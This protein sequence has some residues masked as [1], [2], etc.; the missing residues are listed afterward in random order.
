MTHVDI[1][2]DT[3]LEGFE[4]SPQQARLWRAQQAAPAKPAT[5]VI[6]SERPLDPARLNASLAALIERHEILRT[7]YQ[8]LA[9]MSLPMQVISEPGQ[10]LETLGIELGFDASGTGATLSLPSLHLDSTSL[11]YLA[12]EWA[13]GYLDATLLDPPLQY[14]DYAAWRVEEI[15][16]QGRRFWD[17]Q[18]G[19][20]ATD[21]PLPWLR[22]AG[23]PAPSLEL[24]TLN[25]PL[26]AAGQQ[27]WSSAAS[28]LGITPG[29]LALAAW[30]ALWQRHSEAE[31]LTLGYDNQWRAQ[32][33]G[34][35]LGL[36]AE[37]LP[38]TL[39]A[40]DSTRFATLCQQIE[41]R[42]GV[43]ND[44]R[45]SYPSQDPAAIAGARLPL[46]FRELPA[47]PRSALN[48]AGWQI[49]QADSP[50]AAFALLLQ[51][52]AGAAA[53]LTLHYA[54][55][56]YDETR[57][58]LLAE[59]FVTL[60]LQACREPSQVL[61]G[62]SACSAA[63]QLHQTTTLAASLPLSAAQ[64]QAYGEIADLPHLAAC[65]AQASA[66]AAKR[67]AVS[68]PSGTLSHAELEQR[69]DAL[70]QRLLAQ[71]LE[72]GARIAHFLARD[73]D[74]VVAL[75]AILRAGACYVPI[76]PSY[77]AER[78]EHILRDSQAQWV[79]THSALLHDLPQAGQSRALLIDSTEPVLTRLPEP[80]PARDQAAYL[81]YTSGS[82]GQPKGVVISH[83]NALHS[84]AARLVGYRQPVERFLLLSSFAFDSSIA[85]LFWSLAQRGCLH[86]ASEAEQKDPA[87]LARLIRTHGVSHLLALPSLYALLLEQLGETPSSLNTA[88][89]AGESCPPALVDSHY[90]SQPQ[91]RLYNEYGPTEASVWSTVAE[92][93]PGLGTQPVPIG[94]A[95]AHSHVYLLDADGA[96]VA[97]GLKGEIHIAGPGLSTGYLGLPELT[98]EKFVRA[99]HP[100]LNGQRLYRSGDFAYRDAD[101]QLV[102]LGRTDSQVKLRGYRIELG[103]IE[104]AL[105]KASG[106]SQTVV[107]LDT[108]QAQPSLRA[109]VESHGGQDSASLREALAL[110]LPAHMI[111]ADIQLLAQLPRTANGKADAQALLAMAANHS[112]AP[113]QAPQ[114]HVELV[115]A[116]LWQELLEADVIGRNDDFFALGGHSLLVVRLVHRIRASL[117]V[118]IPVSVMFEHPT[119]A[120]LAEQISQPGLNHAVV[121]LQQGET[122]QPALFCLHQPSG[123]VHHYL[124]M[125]SALPA[126]LPIYGI[127][128]PAGSQARE[129]SLAEL[130]AGYLTLIRAAQPQGPYWL[131]GWSMGGLLALELTRQLEQ[132][133]ET[134][135][136]LALFD[137]TFEAQDPALDADA[138]HA[139]L[140]E[141]LTNESRQRLAP[142]ALAALHAATANRPRMEQLQHALLEWPQVHGL[143]L[144]APQAYV[145]DTLSAMGDARRWVAGY[146]VPKVQARLQLWWAEETLAQNPQLPQRWDALSHSTGHRQVPG[147]HESIL[148]EPTFHAQ[149]NEAL[150]SALAEKAV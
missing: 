123:G 148:G 70:T 25:C 96:P 65:F 50:S 91:A 81:I 20:V 105:C 106:A 95:I 22:H 132:Q 135:E 121:T 119:L 7:H 47:S 11:L 56:A 149:L 16:D 131:C 38:L 85:G 44:A 107:L 122:G 124:P 42:C 125:I 83:A 118:E 63:E 84:L 24:H 37:P 142:E 52:Q 111:P 69:V 80:T 3:Q 5:L 32:V 97:R 17:E 26:D 133:G 74:A 34:D 139:L 39:D 87:Q 147:D 78:I 89:V 128:L 23:Q 145:A 62:L 79:V 53:S 1:P 94:R 108:H 137:S 99:R 68:G 21:V 61:S 75:V 57:V 35:A 59:Q 140:L 126:Q 141:E 30:A 113:Y 109:F 92:C 2:A 29:T 110:M 28:G 8:R 90:R 104:A 82:T 130:A 136:F 76:D 72:P 66:D 114:G 19:N 33:L 112:H 41:E 86:L 51:Y 9:G 88:I 71:D 14:A 54:A 40:S 116:A 146:Q 115:L 120:R 129:A 127:A 64:Q 31:R 77:P 43:L 15:D 117:G 18:L 73:L 98:D 93:Q 4:L 60:L 49:E 36:F 143:T 55:S 48:D 103:E 150:A 6:R 144:K 58:A 27:A 46:G 134:V 101:G 138:L 13:R 10:R 12:E 100:S 67:P 45:D 102:F